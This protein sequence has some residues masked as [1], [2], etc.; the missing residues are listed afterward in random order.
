MPNP[1]AYSLELGCIIRNN[2]ILLLL[3]KIL[4]PQKK[5]KNKNPT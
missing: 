3:S 2:F 5:D 1:L 4:G